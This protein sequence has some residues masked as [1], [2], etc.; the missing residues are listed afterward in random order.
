MSPSPNSVTVV[1]LCALA[2]TAAYVTEFAAS[3]TPVLL[4][5]L[6]RTLLWREA[7]AM[8]WLTADLTE[9]HLVEEGNK[10]RPV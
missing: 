10:K 1:Y 6:H 9:Y 8:E 5:L 2:S 4:A 7:E 3:A